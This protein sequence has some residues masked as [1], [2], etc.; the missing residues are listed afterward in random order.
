[1]GIYGL[2]FKDRGKRLFEFTLQN[3]KTNKKKIEC[4]YV[5]DIILAI[6]EYD[7]NKDWT[8][9]IYEEVKKDG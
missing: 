6:K 7:N 4:K 8:L 1:M 3:K 2:F 5:D 9:L